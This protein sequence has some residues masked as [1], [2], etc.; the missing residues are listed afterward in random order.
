MDYY[1][2][3]GVG[4]Q[5]TA[6]Q[7]RAAYRGKARM[8]HPDVCGD[9]NSTCAFTELAEAYGVLSD[10]EKRRDYDAF[11]DRDRDQ[12]SPRIPVR[13]GLPLRPMIDRVTR[14]LPEDPLPFLMRALQFIGLSLAAV[15]LL[16]AVLYAL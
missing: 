15:I 16:L 12:A 11:L 5:A 3:M 8:C 7:V 4:R 6:T 1:R 10:A 13:F 9:P 2:I 14:W